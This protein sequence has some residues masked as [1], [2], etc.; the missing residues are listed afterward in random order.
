MSKRAFEKI[1]QGLD[2][3]RAY[4]DGTAD[5]SRY[6]VHYAPRPATEGETAAPAK[7]DRSSPRSKLNK[8]G[9]RRSPE[10]RRR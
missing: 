4:L 3:A 9:V 6:R 5:K 8:I 2:E 7:N 1:K 10:S